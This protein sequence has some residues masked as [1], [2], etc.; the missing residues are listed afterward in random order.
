MALSGTVAQWHD[1][2]VWHD[3]YGT[4]TDAN[5]KKLEFQQ[6]RLRIDEMS[7]NTFVCHSST[8]LYNGRFFKKQV[9]DKSLTFKLS[10]SSLTISH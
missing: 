1:G 6:Y 3:I 10:N 7:G 5:L 9:C 8:A 4:M 2:T